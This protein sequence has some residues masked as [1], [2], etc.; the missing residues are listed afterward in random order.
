MLLLETS[1]ILMLNFSKPKLVKI[2][3]EY[4][5]FILDDNWDCCQSSFSL[6]TWWTLEQGYETNMLALGKLISFI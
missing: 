1:E 6:L 5:N 4:K 3:S 2:H